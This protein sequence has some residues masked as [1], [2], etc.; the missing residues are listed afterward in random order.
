MKQQFT[1]VIVLVS[2]FS[3]VAGCS[4][5]DTTKTGVFVDSPVGNI[6]YRTESM[7]S[8]TNAE[9]HFQYKD[10]EK[11]IFSIGGID[12][13]QTQ[14]KSVVTVFDLVGT[15]NVQS[16]AVR[17]IARLLQS[18]DVDGD[19][20]NGIVI[21]DEAHSYAA[22]MSVSFSSESFDDDVINLVANS[23]S[24]QVELVSISEAV[25]HL[26]ESHDL[27]GYYGISNYICKWESKVADGTDNKGTCT[28]KITAGSVGNTVS[29][30][31][32]D[33]F[34]EY[35]YEGVVEGNQLTFGGE[36]P[37]A[38]YTLSGSFEFKENYTAFTGAVTGNFIES[39][40]TEKPFADTIT[41][42]E[43]VNGNF[44]PSF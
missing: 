26:Q 9:G 44:F 10:G 43:I 21:S 20:S 25:A 31:Y 34:V 14:V 12:L 33:G 40:G 3:L 27:P 38:N 28:L 37:E 5:D 15:T 32:G 22:G 39:D 35:E 13:P 8:F 29:V 2:A 42:G 16:T 11:I 7:D 36:I 18:L 30:K 4:E 1:P 17:N 41:D 23:G 19:P 24:S 6:A